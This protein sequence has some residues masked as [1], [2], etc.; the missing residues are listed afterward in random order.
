MGT[1]MEKIEHLRPLHDRVLVRLFDT[2]APEGLIIVRDNPDCV[3]AL[4]NRT[5][6]EHGDYRRVGVHGIVVSVGPGIYDRKFRFRPTTLTPGEVITFTAGW[7]DADG[8]IPGHVL[9]RE[10]DVWGRANA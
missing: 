7:D 3:D 6:G 2:H 10:A 8:A 1:P 9:I 4:N 5:D